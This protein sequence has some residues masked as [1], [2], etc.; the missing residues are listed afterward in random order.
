MQG[1]LL[2]IE[3]IYGASNLVSTVST[4]SMAEQSN[5]VYT[6]LFDKYTNNNANLQVVYPNLPLLQTVQT[7][8]AYP[9]SNWAMFWKLSSVKCRFFEPLEEEHAAAGVAIALRD[10]SISFRV[11]HDI[12]R[13]PE[14]SNG[15]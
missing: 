12:R 3:L 11:P 13:Y 10:W 14:E 5:T 4:V 15:Q 9:A 7:S 6:V 2:I 8:C 1:H